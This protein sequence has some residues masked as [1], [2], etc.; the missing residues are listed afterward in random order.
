M[1][2]RSLAAS[3]A[4]VALGLA[5]AS[6]PGISGEV[7][8]AQVPF[9]VAA[10]QDTAPNFTGISNWFNSRPP[11]ISDLR[12]KGVLVDFWTY[13]CGHCVNTRPRGPEVYSKYKGRRL[14]E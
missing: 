12:G 4:L 5:G 11:N 13:G 10:A 8:R 3:A 2:L 7:P 1:T 6:L 14:I 9:A